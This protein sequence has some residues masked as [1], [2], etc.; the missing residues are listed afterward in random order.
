MF[1]SAV[2]P[3]RLDAIEPEATA[4]RVIAIVIILVTCCLLLWNSRATNF[5]D[6]SMEC[7][8]SLLAVRSADLFREQGVTFGLLE[9]MG[10]LAEPNVYTHNVNLGGFLLIGAELLGVPDRYFFIAALLVFALGLYYVYLTFLYFLKS[11][12]AA[13]I[14]LAV[15]A[16]TF[17]GLGAFGLNP[18]R[19]W[20][21]VAFFAVFLH[22]S[23]IVVNAGS[24][25]AIAGLIL[26]ALAAFG[27]GY[28]F[29]MICGATAA[30]IVLLSPDCTWRRKIRAA[31]IVGAIFAL[32]FILRQIHVAMV[33]GA[34]YWVQDFIYSVAIKVPY[35]DRLIQI[36]SLDEIDAYYRAH[37]VMRPPAQPGNVA[38][39]IFFTFRHM[40]EHITVPRWGLI[41]L[42][43]TLLCFLAALIPVFRKALL[44]AAS[45][46]IVLPM[47][48]GPTIG[49]IV[50]S[51]FALHVYFKHEFPLLAFPLLAAKALV[52]Y[53]LVR[54]IVAQRRAVLSTISAA[55]CIFIIGLDAGL[56]HWNNTEH[57][58]YPNFAWVQFYREHPQ[59]NFALSTYQLM[60]YATQ[61][62]GATQ[63]VDAYFP[64]EKIRLGEEPTKPFW[65][66]QPVDYMTDFDRTMPTCRWTGW[67]RELRGK[68]FPHQ[69]GIS[70]VYDQVFI[71]AAKPAPLSLDE[72]AS[73]VKT[74]EVIERNDLGIGYLIM[75]KKSSL[76]AR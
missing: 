42:G 62:T 5:L 11:N 41:T 58:E 20:H 36:P 22:T 7:G 74:Y 43:L 13:I 40:V 76:A 57:S 45:Y 19:A 14:A 32:P 33:L 72:V 34:D 12:L 9:N 66:Y 23:Q 37:H 24:K 29:W 73:R 53:A 71:P 55:V 3:R 51:P 64:P 60:G 48:L 65:I 39:Q 70:C 17:W 63:T 4:G 6:C 15:F 56:V 68:R 35:A 52:L 49:L 2:S 1:F 46:R 25:V 38:W 28:D 69:P 59:D 61:F 10:T 67:L 54:I 75:R 47:L 31:F 44:V 21:L 30:S 8:E 16:S 26:G 27:C 50:L 18:L